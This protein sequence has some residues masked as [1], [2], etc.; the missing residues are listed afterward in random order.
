MCIYHLRFDLVGSARLPRVTLGSSEK[1]REGAGPELVSQVQDRQILGDSSLNQNNFSKRPAPAPKP[2]LPPP[3]PRLTFVVFFC[4]SR[5]LLV[6]ASQS[7]C[8]CLL[9]T[10]P[11]TGILK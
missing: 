5:V 11:R 2:S 4:D 3:A 10:T 1:S 9:R 7:F 6:F 8:V